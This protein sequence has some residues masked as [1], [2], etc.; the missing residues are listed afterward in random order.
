MKKNIHINNITFGYVDQP[1]FKNWSVEIP[2]GIV[3]IRCDESR[4]KSTLLRLIAGK[5]Q[6]Q[7]G[8]LSINDTGSIIHIEPSTDEFDQISVTAFFKQCQKHYPAMDAKKLDALI[9]GLS[10]TTHLDKPIYMLSAGSKRKVWIAAALASNA[11]VAL[12]DD[13][14]AAL[15]KGSIDYLRRELAEQ[16]TFAEDKTIIVTHYDTLEEVPF[17]LTIDI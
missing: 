15:D 1:L 12:I 9:Q 3:L 11:R 4:G 13:L 16:A 17:S 8:Q 7:S 10:L 2:A 14:T 5:L 6:P